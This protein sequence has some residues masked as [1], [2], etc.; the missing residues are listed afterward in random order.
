MTNLQIKTKLLLI[1]FIIIAT[2]TTLLTIQSLNTIEQVTKQNINLYEKQVI[3]AKKES[4]K[5]HVNMLQGVLQTYRDK[6]IEHSTQDE[7]E[8]IKKDAIQALDSMVYGDDGYVFVWTYEGVPLAYHP[9]PDLIGKNLIN[10]K[11]GDGKFAIRELIKSAKKGGGHFYTYKWRTTQKGDYQT[12]I[13]YSFGVEEWGW[14]IGTGQYMTKEENIISQTK[15]KLH[16]NTKELIEKTIIEALILML[17]ISILFYLLLQKMITQP[18]QK[19]QNGLNDFFDFLQN[20]KTNVTPIKIDTNDEFGKMIASINE[21]IIVSSKLHHKINELNK[22]LETKVNERT[23]EVQNKEQELQHI[24]NTIMESVMILENG[25]IIDLNPQAIKT[26]GLKNLQ[27]GLGLTPLDFVPQYNHHIVLAGLKNPDTPPYQFDVLKRDGT[28]F[29]ALIHGKN[30]HINNKSLRVTSFLDISELKNTEKALQIAKQKAEESTKA[31]SEFL[32]NMS[33]EI[34]T[35]MNGIIGMSHLALQTQLNDKQKNY[36][37][38]IDSSAKSLLGIINDILD[39]SKIEAGKLTIEKVDFDISEML[40]N[41]VNLIEFKVHEKN[42]KLIINYDTSNGK[43]FYGDTLRISQVLTN[44]LSNALKFTELGQICVNIKKID[45]TLFRFEVKDTG[46]GLKQE[47][48]KKLFQSFSQADGTTTRKYGGTGLG[49]TISKQLVELMGGNIWVESEEGVG[50]KFIFEIELEIGDSKNVKAKDSD[51]LKSLE[52][53][54]KTLEGSNI[55]LVEDNQINQEIIIGLL[56]NSA[57]N[58]DIAND[59]KEAVQ[60]YQLYPKKYELILMDLQMPIMGGIEAT[61]IIRETNKEIPIIALTANAMKED[62]ERTAQAL[63]NEHLNKPIELEKLYE[64]LLK[65]ISKKVKI[66]EPVPNEEKNTQEIIVPIFKNID[67]KL[68]LSYS[69]NNKKLYLKILNSFYNN[70]K[71]LDLDSLQDEDLE[72]FAH[73]LK[74]LAANIGSIGVVE[75]ASKIEETLDKNLLHS[76]K[77]ELSEVL[78]ELKIFKEEN[79][80]T[81]LLKLDKQKRDV[82]FESLKE[83][84]KT[85]RINKITPVIEE[86]RKYELSKEDISILNLVREYK[87]KETLEKI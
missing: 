52:Q 71:D 22:N 43:Y 34:R 29:P 13:S 44:L 4:L 25:K 6:I 70:Y 32:A 41:V 19:L 63:M 60:M 61:K 38:K 65:Y 12:K 79:Q 86:I 77:I 50:S 18:L 46:I 23:K 87:F 83:A 76:L 75:I 68:G 39:F 57:L 55:L 47:Q 73:S 58:I 66:K 20:K 80:E 42:L 27:E 40:N 64:T 24:L 7:I 45:S 10:M 15:E 36:L 14:L 26:F 82:L 56:E 30:L 67:T 28:I 2:I 81:E 8:A 11:S 78:D 53:N 51:K 5:N 1:V 17:I 74:G 16:A 62:K 72:I 3:D 9:R 21:N 48:I 49:L 31:K 37:Q 59:G 85:K 69:A 33:H 35:P 54:I 84:L